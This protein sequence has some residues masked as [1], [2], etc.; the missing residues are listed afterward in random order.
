M[1]LSVEMRYKVLQISFFVLLSIVDGIRLQ[2]F[3][4]LGKVTLPI[5][6]RDVTCE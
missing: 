3:G 1:L 4:K 5:N 6:N 2:M